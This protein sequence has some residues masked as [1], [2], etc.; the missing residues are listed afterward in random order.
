MPTQRGGSHDDWSPQAQVVPRGS[1]SSQRTLGI[2]W[3]VMGLNGGLWSLMM[4]NH[5]FIDG[6]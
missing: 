2:A 5:D 3:Q 1:P 6:I 4:V